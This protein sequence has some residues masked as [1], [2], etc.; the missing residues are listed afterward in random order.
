MLRADRGTG[1]FCGGLARRQQ[2]CGKFLFSPLYSSSSA[3]SEKSCQEE[4]FMTTH[5]ALLRW[6]HPAFFQS[7]ALSSLQRAQKRHK[8][9]H[10]RSKSVVEINNKRRRRRSSANRLPPTLPNGCWS[11]ATLDATNA[12]MFD[13]DEGNVKED[14]RDAGAC[15]HGYKLAADVDSH[16][17]LF[18]GPHPN[19]ARATY[20]PNIR[21][22]LCFS[23]KPSSLL[24][25]G[26]RETGTTNATST[27]EQI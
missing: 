3:H 5:S 12:K 16:A 1:E 26:A 22:C 27:S 21:L 19:S 25:R 10:R 13:N 8:G 11:A 6:E 17:R 18:H 14:D 15:G 2:L 20:L 7:S 9:P 24:Y 23:L 4:D